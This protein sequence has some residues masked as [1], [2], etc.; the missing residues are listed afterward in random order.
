VGGDYPE[1]SWVKTNKGFATT[2]FRNYRYPIKPDVQEFW[3]D[4]NDDGT[5]QPEEL[6][7][8]MP[9]PMTNEEGAPLYQYFPLLEGIRLYWRGGAQVFLDSLTVK[10]EPV[11]EPQTLLGLATAAGL[12]AFFKRELNKT[13][14]DYEEA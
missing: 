3:F 12:G 6:A 9:L 8:S 7:A 5:F 2:S 14:K 1:N 13:N 11:P 4:A 10:A